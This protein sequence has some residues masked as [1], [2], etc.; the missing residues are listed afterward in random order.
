[1]SPFGPLVLQRPP[2][3]QCKRTPMGMRAPKAGDSV[4]LIFSF[5]PPLNADPLRYSGIRACPWLPP[6]SFS[7]K[8]WRRRWQLRLGRMLRPSM[9][10]N[11][12]SQTPL[13]RPSRR[14]WMSTMKNSRTVSVRSIKTNQIN[15]VNTHTRHKCTPSPTTFRVNSSSPP[16]TGSTSINGMRLT[17]HP[18]TF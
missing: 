17:S 13:A 15:L 4:S 8:T 2:Y 11:S 6:P 7:W 9:K 12:S 10:M 14:F 16:R 3:P 18:R 1:M 5:T